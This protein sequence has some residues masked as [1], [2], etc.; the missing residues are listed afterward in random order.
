MQV[1]KN[2]MASE[3]GILALA[4]IIGATVL[5]ALGKM[6]LPEWQEYSIYI[7]GIYVGG[8]SI[9]GAASVI[10]NG[11]KTDGK[12]TKAKIAKDARDAKDAKDIDGS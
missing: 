10:A 12:S 3:K 7:F 11:K 4:L 1:I 8:K 9:Q 6:P 2:F 5:T